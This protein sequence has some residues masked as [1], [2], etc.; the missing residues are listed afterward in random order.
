[1]DGERVIAMAERGVR[2][3]VIRLPPLVHSVFDRRGLFPQLID[4]AHAQGV[5]GYVGD[6]ANRWPAVHTVDVAGSTG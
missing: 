4:V 2:S 6:G 3:S 5:C 1:V